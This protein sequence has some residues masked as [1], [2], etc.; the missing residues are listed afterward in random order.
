MHQNASGE[1][2]SDVYRESG[3]G[4]LRSVCLRGGAEISK[5]HGHGMSHTTSF[6]MRSLLGWTQRNGRG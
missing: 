4:K 3:G 1:N 6:G 5:D 2:S